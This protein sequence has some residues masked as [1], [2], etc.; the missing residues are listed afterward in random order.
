MQWEIG[1]ETQVKVTIHEGQ[2]GVEGV[3]QKQQ[4]NWTHVGG[5]SSFLCQPV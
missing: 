1:N 4:Q 5:C 2:F 3:Q